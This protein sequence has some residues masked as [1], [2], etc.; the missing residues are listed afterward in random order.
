MGLVN[1]PDCSREISSDATQCPQ[2]GYAPPTR[3]PMEFTPGRFLVGLVAL[4]VAAYGVFVFIPTHTP[5][6]A[7]RAEI[8][9]TEMSL[10][11]VLRRLA[12]HAVDP[13]SSVAWY[14]TPFGRRLAYGTAA[15]LGVIGLVCVGTSR[16]RL[17][18]LVFCRRCQRRR[19]AVLALLS[20]T[21]E[22]CHSSRNAITSQRRVSG[23]LLLAAL[24][25]IGWFVFAPA[26]HLQG[27]GSTTESTSSPGA[28]VNLT[29]A[30]VF[31]VRV[32]EAGVTTAAYAQND[33]HATGGGLP[34]LS[35][36]VQQRGLELL[37]TRAMKD[38]AVVH[39]PD[40]YV[41]VN[42]RPG[43]T[44]EVFVYDED[45]FERD[46]LAHWRIEPDASG[47]NVLFPERLDHAGVWVVLSTSR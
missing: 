22:T 14:L 13:E 40:G 29:V 7:L 23:L 19:L 38:Q 10:S 28:Q 4:G 41:R 21:C 33:D 2:C 37:R 17:R 45:A 20:A 27:S 1:C 46:L 26:R 3:P 42:W 18:D 6:A 9:G 44:L 15:A 36:V 43:D 24:L 16:R 34:E 30:G 47:G 35:V 31:R 5:A 39:P 12:I 25:G 32:V 8:E 11:G